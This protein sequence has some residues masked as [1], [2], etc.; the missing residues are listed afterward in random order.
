[1]LAYGSI[2]RG[3]VNLD[4]DIE[5]FIPTPPSPTLIQAILDRYEVKLS[6]RV[7]VQATPRYAA[8]AYLNIDGKKGYS[9]PLV[10]LKQNEAEF[11]KF[12]GSVD[13]NQIQ[14][15]IR[16]PGVNKELLLIEPTSEGHKQSPIKGREGIVAKKLGVDPSI[17]LERLRTLER[18][19][20]VGHTGVFLKRDLAPDE[21][22]SKVFRELTRRT[23]AI[24]R[25]LRNK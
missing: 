4:S 22:I 1:V 16:V 18:R 23:P 21:D 5:I 7:I 19:R 25:R 6:N 24:R 20:R 12:A 15:S 10:E 11:F 13:L 3:D 2:A 14:K 17:V 8:K 9:F